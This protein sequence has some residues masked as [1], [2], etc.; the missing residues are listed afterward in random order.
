MTSKK[1]EV[2]FHEQEY[3]KQLTQL[4]NKLNQLN[5]G[6]QL[7]KTITDNTVKEFDLNQ[8]NE[9][10][11]QKIDMPNLEAVADMLNQKNNYLKLAE[12]YGKKDEL[13]SEY[14]IFGSGSYNLKEDALQTL[15]RANTTYLS[16]DKVA[17]YK[18]LEK[19]VNLLNTLS[20]EDLTSMQ[21]TYDG[22]Y[23]INK[24]RLNTTW[25]F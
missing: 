13:E 10:L 5:T 6:V 11:K 24:Q 16:N 14:I 3:N 23:L 22:K 9:Y 19:A 2:A 21:K 8:V 7:A 17:T 1:I 20:P 15:K 12:I 4:D 25:T 18:T